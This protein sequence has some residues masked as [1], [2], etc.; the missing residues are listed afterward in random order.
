MPLLA[1]ASTEGH[2][3]AGSVGN[4]PLCVALCS[5]QQLCESWLSSR[6]QPAQ[7]ALQQS[8]AHHQTPL[9]ALA[10]H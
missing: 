6:R 10:H 1:G 3:Q 8:T 4:A 2:T 7:H 9:L 5:A